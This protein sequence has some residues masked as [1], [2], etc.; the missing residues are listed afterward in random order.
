MLTIVSDAESELRTSTH[1]R[2][3][4][5]LALLKMAALT[6]TVD[7]RK[8]LARLDELPA[9]VQSGRPVPKKPEARSTPRDDR[10][11]VDGGQNVQTPPP[12]P[13]P[14]PYTSPRRPPT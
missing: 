10:G 13:L 2:L 3:R 4:V 7:I 9:G 11:Q 5:E 12:A 14:P 6:S 8:I 1:P